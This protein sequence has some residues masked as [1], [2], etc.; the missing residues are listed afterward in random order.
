MIDYMQME[1][2]LRDTGVTMRQ[3]TRIVRR[4]RRWVPRVTAIVGTVVLGIVGAGGSPSGATGGQPATTVVV[5]PPAVAGSGT[6]A[7][8]PPGLVLALSAVPTAAQE[9]RQ[10][11]S[12]G[13]RVVVDGNALPLTSLAAGITGAERTALRLE[14]MDHY[15]TPTISSSGTVGTSTTVSRSRAFEIGKSLVHSAPSTVVPRALAGAVLHAM[16]VHEAQQDGHMASMAKARATAKQEEKAYETAVASGTAPTLPVGVSVW[17][18]YR[19][20]AA[21]KYYQNLLTYTDEMR[22]V[23]PLHAAGG[24]CLDQTAELAAWMAA[25]LGTQG[26]R[27]AGARGLTARDLPHHLAIGSQCGHNVGV[28]RGS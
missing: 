18:Q 4:S 6:L 27:V 11:R 25:H 23:A 8:D 26:V 28:H 10:L 20:K 21:V 2:K 5:Q 16:L 17:Q 12:A 3:W 22:R 24:R 9:A 14:W 1:Y 13:T 15:V 7:Q 19:S